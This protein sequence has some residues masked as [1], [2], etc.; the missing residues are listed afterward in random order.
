[1]NKTSSVFYISSISR[2]NTVAKATAVFKM[3]LRDLEQKRNHPK[4]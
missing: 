2:G 3:C 1:M 4:W